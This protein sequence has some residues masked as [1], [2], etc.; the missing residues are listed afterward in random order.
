[1]GP[2]LP[3]KPSVLCRGGLCGE[4][5]PI[6]VDPAVLQGQ[7]AGGD[8]PIAEFCLMRKLM[9]LV[10]AR[11]A[12]LLQKVGNEARFQRALPSLEFPACRDVDDA[13]VL[14]PRV[15]IRA[16]AKLY[17]TTEQDFFDHVA[18][19]APRLPEHTKGPSV[20]LGPVSQNVRKMWNASP[21]TR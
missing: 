1:M 12:R 13:K 15:T 18:S 7:A 17:A 21:S 20:R 9:E 5:L 8:K 16:A 10:G 2:A 19:L 4:A 14:D 6:Q 11:V 3:D